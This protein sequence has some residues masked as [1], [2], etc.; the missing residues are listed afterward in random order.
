MTFKLTP[1]NREAEL[2][3]GDRMWL[4]PKESKVL[5]TII[6]EAPR[7]IRSAKIAR[8]VFGDR[9]EVLLVNAYVSRIRRKIGAKHIVT[10][11]KFGYRL[12]LGAFQGRS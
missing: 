2:P 11:S 3:N 8:I 5:L 7:A 4:D 9:D 1:D 10:I 12:M 6:D